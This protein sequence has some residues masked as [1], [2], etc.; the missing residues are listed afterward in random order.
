MIDSKNSHTT[1]H[2]AVYHPTDYFARY[3]FP[4]KASLLQGQVT[5]IWK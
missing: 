4:A 2:R 3:F 5:S 1:T